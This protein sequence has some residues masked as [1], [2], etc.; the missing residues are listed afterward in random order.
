MDI[1]KDL[2]EKYFKNQA[3]PDEVIKV[4]K[5]FRTPE[6]QKYLENC[7]DSDLSKMDENTWLSIRPINTAKILD[8][9]YDP[10]VEPVK[11][12]L[13]G[14]NLYWKIA[15]CFA[16][17]I[18]ASIAYVA[19]YKQGITYETKYGEKK[20]IILPDNSK[21]ILNGNSSLTISHE[22]SSESKRE[23]WLQGEAFFSVFHTENNN[24]FVVYTSDNFNIQV[25]GT[26]FN[27]VNRESVT[28]VALEKGHIQLNFSEK[29]KDSR[30][31]MIPGEFVEFNEKS[32]FLIKKEIA[33]K[34]IVSWKSTL[35]VFEQ[36]S[37]EEVAE[38]LRDTYGLTM[39]VSDPSIM[40]YK[41]TGT[42]PNQNLDLL[43]KGLMEI[44]D[45]K[46]TREENLLYLNKNTTNQTN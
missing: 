30:L 28:K 44:L 13:S 35:M 19:T 27:V 38:M 12:K 37:M 18:I 11:T 32:A 21:V 14:F 43:L 31:S 16:L 5:A 33:V 8:N 34:N 15:A 42:V 45:V 46:I 29:G 6:G 26:E 3:S 36:T 1:S 39:I 24:D 23:V 20:E 40:E 2:V 17:I 9:I 7:L 41:I 22:W 4:L 10:S 25:L